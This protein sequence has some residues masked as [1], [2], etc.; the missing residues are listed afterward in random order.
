MKY[1]LAIFISI[2]IALLAY[3]T[4][5]K[6][7]ASK[8]RLFKPADPDD[9]FESKNL[10]NSQMAFA[11]IIVTIL[12]FVSV[13]QIQHRVSSHL[14]IAKMIIAI[15]CLP[16]AA[17]LEFREKRLPNIITGAMAVL[18]VAF[19]ITGLVL[20]QDG[21]VAYIT[22]SV[23]ATAGCAIFMVIAAFLTKQGI[24]AGDIKLISALAL[25]G[26]VY[27]IIGTLFFGMLTCCT[28][29][30]FAILLKKKTIRE[31]VPFGPFLLIGFVITLF[32]IPF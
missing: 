30:V 3:I 16:G 4:L 7:T 14:G 20:Q 24:G 31:A 28:Y 25:I 11:I 6:N 15:L 2:I 26:G 23:F 32:V 18:G 8:I 19:L 12:G 5:N 17:W 22:S 9:A 27:T 10:N 29:A 21:A 13:L 1:V